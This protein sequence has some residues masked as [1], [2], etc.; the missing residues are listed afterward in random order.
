MSRFTNTRPLPRSVTAPPRLPNYLPTGNGGE[1]IKRDA[2]TELFLLATVNTVGHDTFYETAAKRDNRFKNLVVELTK[3]DPNWVYNLLVWLRSEG[4]MRTASIVGAIEYT[5]AGGPNGRKLIDAVLQRPDEPG[6][7]IAYYRLAHRRTLSASVLR[8]VRDGVERMYSEWSALKYDGQSKGYRFG[9]VVEIVHPHPKTTEQ[10]QLYKALTLRARG[11]DLPSE[12]G[13]PL[14]RK[15]AMLQ[16]LSPKHRFAHLQDA[17]QIGWS[18]ERLAS[19]LPKAHHKEM[20]EALAPKLNYM[21]LLRNLRN[22]E[23]A[24]VSMET[25]N[26]VNARLS[27]QEEVEKSR[28]LPMRF[29]SAFKH[30]SMQWHWALEQAL[31]HSMANVPY[32]KGRTL[33][34]VDGSGSMNAPVSAGK[35]GK[36]DPLTRWEA[37]KIF[38][39]TIAVRSENPAVLVFTTGVSYVAKTERNILTTIKGM[40]FPQGGTN[41]HRSLEE[42]LQAVGGRVDRVIILTDEQTS[43]YGRM[44]VTV[45]VYVFNVAGHEAGLAPS[46]SRWYS[47][48]GLTDA[49]FDMIEHLDRGRDAAWPWQK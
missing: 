21:A 23:E 25:I 43:D 16:Q 40:H 31:N 2:K 34:L 46:G 13:V 6:E 44:D 27:S 17:I 22:M 10:D 24:T 28:Q 8:G 32:F 41:I 42:G 48:G 30:T 19:W 18:W 4:N 37:S 5:M 29:L 7:A 49:C 35:R 9:Q 26:L 1:G 45:P 15:D 33:V 39:A 11:R 36:A 12:I 47:F 14:F 3:E 38:A 20:W